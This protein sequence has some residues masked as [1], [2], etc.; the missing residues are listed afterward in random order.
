MH[1]YVI[2]R[3]QRDRL[4]RWVN[5]LLARYY[6]YN[7]DNKTKNVKVQLAVRPIQ[8]YEIVFPE[9]HYEAVVSAI[10]PYGGYNFNK[11]IFAHLRNILTKMLRLEPIKQD[12]KADILDRHN[13]PLYRDFVDVAGIGVKK[14]KFIDG[15]EQ[16]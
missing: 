9:E 16:L 11:G 7:M 8:L 3:G 5:D 12:V 15:I 2:A 14:D 6:P 1:L 13:T 4:E 10:Q